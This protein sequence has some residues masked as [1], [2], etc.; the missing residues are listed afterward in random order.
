MNIMLVSQCNKKAL[1][2]T[3]RIIDQFAERRGDRTWQTPITQ[4][5]LATLRKLLKKTA[6]RN[7]AV[8]C[9][10]IR[11]KNHTEIL[12]IVGNVSKFNE[13]GAVPTNTTR[14][15][16]LRSDSENTWHTAEDI[17]LL[18][19]I[20]ALFHD[21]GKANLLFQNK[22]K[23]KKKGKLLEP[24][25]HEWVSLRMFEAFVYGLSDE[26]WLAKLAEVS[27]DDNDIMINN[28][29][30]DHPDNPQTNPFDPDKPTRLPPTARAIA[31]LIL[32]HHKLP[33]Y[34][35]RGSN[36][37][38]F[39]Y[40]AEFLDYE[41]KPDWNS[42]QIADSN[43]FDDATDKPKKWTDK[44]LNSVWDFNHKTP[45]LSKTW[46][47]K[48]QLLAKR[49]LNRPAFLNKAWLD[50]TFTLHLSRMALMLA[51]HHYSSLPADE[52]F[53]DKK[54][55]VYANT[56]RDTGALKQQL[57]EH[58]IGV[59]RNSLQLVRLL[60]SLRSGL[61]AITRH[62]GLKQRSKISAFSWQDK[63]YDVA[64][65][66]SD[67]SRQ[68]G[69]FGIN[70]ASTGKGKTFANARIMYGL[71]D[72]KLGCR[73]SIA[74][75]LRTLT[76]QTGDALM[77]R[78]KLDSDDL[79]VL[80][81][82]QS[83]KQLHDLAQKYHKAANNSGSESANDFLDADQYVKYEGALHDG[84]LKRWLEKSAKLN[85]LVSAP[86]L[87]STIDHIMPATESERGG[88]QIA[89]MLRLLTADLVLDE[90]DDF[91]LLD[92]PAICR[93]VNWAGLL[94]ARVLLSSATL[95]PALVTTLFAAYQAGRKRFNEAC[96]IPGQSSAIV[97]GWFDE[98][99]S[100][101]HLIDD[102]AG[103]TKTH[104]QFVDQR[105]VK[106]LK[107][108]SI[109][110]GKLVDVDL[111][112][113]V[114]HVADNAKAVLNQRAVN[115]LANRL[116]ESINVL[117]QHHATINEQTDQRLS[118]GVVRMAN[119]KPLVAVATAL[120][121][122]AAMADHQIHYCVYHSKMPLIVRSK[123]EAQLD[124]VL[125]RDDPQAV[126]QQPSI[127]QAL[128]K[129]PAKNHIF[130]VLASPVCEV[131]RDHDYDWAIVEPSSMRSIIQLAGRVQR[132]RN[133][134]PRQPNIHI[135][136]QNFK[137]LTG[138]SP[139]FSKPGFESAEHQLKSTN[140]NELLLSEQ[141]Q[142]INAIG[143]IRFETDE[144]ADPADNLVAF[145]HQQLAHTLALGE[146]KSEGKGEDK[147]EGKS[148]ADIWWH[149]PTNWTY[150]WQRLTRFRQS[151]PTDDYVLKVTDVDEGFVFYQWAPNGELKNAEYRFERVPSVKHHLAQGVQLW[152][153]GLWGA[154]D[155]QA[156]IAAL[157]DEFKLSETQASVMFGCV[158]L[159]EQDLW[160]YD[161]VLG[162]YQAL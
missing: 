38:D 35:A 18:A 69:F 82:S 126:W 146:G 88:K 162:F 91:D 115:G 26:H 125:R 39:D 87:V 3:R 66:I 49:A 25:R 71:A 97:C 140:L 13:Q 135:L 83:V 43:A 37:P 121:Q 110:Q 72:S 137:A 15:N 79:A 120:F 52:R 92:L 75:G 50:D 136:K 160:Y 104:S 128:A 58:L 63:A 107:A 106:L 156:S 28:L 77:S 93:L 76:L 108:P 67:K 46:R 150:E 48:A 45:V 105:I 9:H 147:G 101:A 132:H 86:V 157:A 85:S 4:I 54:Y 62:K 130:V 109:R 59:Y 90:I 123:I 153:V 34:Q 40:V 22:L 33:K 56:D 78:L 129:S 51:D 161:E 100:V 134:S 127:K 143:R 44:E 65:S 84:P 8:A 89:P 96:G 64:R 155:Y 144:A 6:R 103:L 118:I 32:T 1:V 30:K 151:A 95:P 5:G 20:A 131:G 14:R 41:L 119:I 102:E 31:W 142:T 12:W 47:L 159:E 99:Q 145:E 158:S 80:I 55:K 94:G 21:F 27:V 17:A 60:P 7:T 11:S 74:L 57:D 141:Y 70:M 113:A 53:Q 117:H 122:R 24:Y 139:A 148:T 81:G 10:W 23:P 124:S 16:I 154:G 138:Q 98:F 111:A 68:Q 149:Q 114:E 116:F 133:L 152:G 2:E 61:G 112:D 73:F 36:P 19:G 42:P 29:V